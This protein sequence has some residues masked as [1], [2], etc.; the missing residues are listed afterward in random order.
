[1]LADKKAH[2]DIV[3]ELYLATLS[4]FPNAKEQTVWRQQLAESP[5][6]KAFYEDLLWSLLNS[7]QFLFVR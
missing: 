7:K 3:N 2:D 4:R 1:L 5:S 6:V